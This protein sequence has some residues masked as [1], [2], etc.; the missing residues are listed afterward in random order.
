MFIPDIDDS[1]DVGDVGLGRGSL[2]C[3]AEGCE[4]P[5]VPS[6]APTC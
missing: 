4:V 6:H 1:G 2:V 3:D 5:A